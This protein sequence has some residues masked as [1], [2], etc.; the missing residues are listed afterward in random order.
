MGCPWVAKVGRIQCTGWGLA[1]RMEHVNLRGRN[2]L[3]K[4]TGRKQSVCLQVLTGGGIWG[5]EPS[6]F[7]SEFFH[8]PWSRKDH[9]P[10]VRQGEV[11][12]VLRKEKPWGHRWREWKSHWIGVCGMM[13][14]SLPVLLQVHS[15]GFEVR[16]LRVS[17]AWS[18]VQMQKWNR[19]RVGFCKWVWQSTRGTNTLRVH[20]RECFIMIDRGT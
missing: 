6:R 13:A 20:I 1:F 4:C 5:W 12:G 14:S 11:I 16:A 8:S 15:Q 2:F 7:S 17:P 19:W 10:E 3:W 18:V 9:Q